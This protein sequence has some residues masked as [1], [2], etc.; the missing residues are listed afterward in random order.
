MI[1]LGSLTAV[2]IYLIVAGLIW[3]IL[4]WAVRTIDPPQPFKK[5]AEVVLV[6]VVV[7]V[8]IGALLSLVSG[9]PLFRP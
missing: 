5:V 6:L 9:Q 2:V 7:L 4:F 8:I 1:S 3:W